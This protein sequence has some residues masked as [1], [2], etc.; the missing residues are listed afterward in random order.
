MSGVREE[1][2]VVVK[3]WIG[4]AASFSRT[5][6]SPEAGLLDLAIL[7]TGRVLGG[8]VHGA[9]RWY[10]ELKPAS[11]CLWEYRNLD[12]DDGTTALPAADLHLVDLWDAQ[13]PDHD[14][15][16]TIGETP[17]WQNVRTDATK[18]KAGTRFAPDDQVDV[19]ADVV[20]AGAYHLILNGAWALLIE[21]HRE[22]CLV[23]TPNDVDQEA[24]G[25]SFDETERPE[26]LPLTQVCAPQ[27][28]RA[29]ERKD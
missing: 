2:E 14:A 15:H 5:A 12:R 25:R 23:M 27:A 7:I 28:P 20:A 17:A 11:C 1:T 13:A 19:L 10:F 24:V 26:N 4:D 21:V 29:E 6:L 3:T 16:R 8:L 22:G 9:D 18:A